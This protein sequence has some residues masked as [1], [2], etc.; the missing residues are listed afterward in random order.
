M[1]KALIY[2]FLI[3]TMAFTT[4]SSVTAQ[5]HPGQQSSGG[6]TGDR[7]GDGPSGAPVGNGTFILLA[8][9]MAYAGHKAYKGQTAAEETE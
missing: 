2:T 6:V 4:A 3:L 9:A 5:P 1:K 7:I 8:L